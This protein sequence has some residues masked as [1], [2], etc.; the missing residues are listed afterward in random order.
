MKELA[1]D[2]KPF[3]EDQY[4]LD[5]I[6]RIIA[7]LQSMDIFK[8]LGLLDMKCTTSLTPS[9]LFHIG[10]EIY[11]ATFATRHDIFISRRYQGYVRQLGRGEVVPGG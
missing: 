5:D 9:G 7:T 11:A 6:Y 2:V 1:E 8:N 10:K 4:V 3:V